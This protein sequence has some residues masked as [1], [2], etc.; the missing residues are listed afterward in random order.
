MTSDMSISHLTLSLSH[1]LICK[2]KGL[3]LDLL[4]IFPGEQ[5][6]V[7]RWRVSLEPLGGRLD[8]YLTNRSRFQRFLGIG[9]ASL[10]NF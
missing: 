1:L 4:L 3:L 10:G 8:F 6:F 5:L 7:Q 9:S 2:L